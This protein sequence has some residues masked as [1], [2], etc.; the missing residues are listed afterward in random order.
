MEDYTILERD[1]PAA[2]KKPKFSLAGW[3]LLLVL[4]LECALVYWRCG[5]DRPENAIIE[6]LERYHRLPEAAFG[7]MVE[8]TMGKDCPLAVVYKGRYIILHWKQMDGAIIFAKNVVVDGDRATVT[9]GTEKGDY[10]WAECILMRWF[11]IK[12]R[13]HNEASGLEDQVYELA[14]VN[15]KW[16]PVVTE[17]DFARTCAFTKEKLAAAAQQYRMTRMFREGSNP[18]P[19]SVDDLC[20]AKLLRRGEKCPSGGTYSFE[21]IPDGK[22]AHEQCRCAVKCSKHQ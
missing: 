9:I 20:S 11:G 10:S 5:V 13:R 7:Q 4:A 16:V 14:K 21:A 3:F 2:V 15:G 22:Y 19:T 6:L 8:T 18:T 1:N 12:V 17:A